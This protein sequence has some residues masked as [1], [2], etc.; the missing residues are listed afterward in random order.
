MEL[1]DHVPDFCLIND[2][3]GKFYVKNK[4]FLFSLKDVTV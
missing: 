3:T 4:M 1:W 2:N